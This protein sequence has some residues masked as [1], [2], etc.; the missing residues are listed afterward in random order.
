MARVHVASAYDAAAAV[1]QLQQGI[2]MGEAA[3]PP[4]PLLIATLPEQPVHIA[5]AP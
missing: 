5:E 1:L 3:L 4:A 2:R